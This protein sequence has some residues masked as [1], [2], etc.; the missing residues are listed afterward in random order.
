[1]SRPRTKHSVSGQGLTMRPQRLPKQPTRSIVINYNVMMCQT[2]RISVTVIS[3]TAELPALGDITF[4]PFINYSFISFRHVHIYLQYRMVKHLVQYSPQF[5]LLFRSCLITALIVRKFIRLINFV[6]FNLREILH[7]IFIFYND[8]NINIRL[9]IFST[10]I[11]S[12]VR[13]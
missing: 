5:A 12:V 6:I 4:F 13:D 1:M 2:S 8:R 11:I 7:C 3:T 10:K 9:K